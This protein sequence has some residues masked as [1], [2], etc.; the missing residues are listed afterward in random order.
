M[1]VLLAGLEDALPQSRQAAA[2]A[3][4]SLGPLA[5]EAVGALEKTA[6][7]Q[8]PSVREAAAKALRAIAGRGAN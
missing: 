4:G 7:D 3:L 8:E 5:K 6:N 2:D 1:P